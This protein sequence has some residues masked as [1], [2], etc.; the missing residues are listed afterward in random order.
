MAFVYKTDHPTSDEA[1][2]PGDWMRSMDAMAGE[3]NGKMDRDNLPEAVVDDT[4]IADDTI[5]LVTSANGSLV[6]LSG[7][8]TGWVSSVSGT[9][10]LTLDFTADVDMVI[11]VTCSFT[12][13]WG[14]AYNGPASGPDTDRFLVGWRLVVDGTEIAAS[15]DHSAIRRHDSLL[16]MGTYVAPPGEHTVRLEG[17]NRSEVGGQSGIDLDF[18]RGSLILEQVRR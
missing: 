17:W 15:H 16:L 2:D 6:T 5:T 12:W 7:T 8:D 10:M 14:Y 18:V 13:L 4:H 9:D 1:L 3:F 11:D